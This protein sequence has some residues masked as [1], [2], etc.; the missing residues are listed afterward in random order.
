MRKNRPAFLWIAVIS[1]LLLACN[2]AGKGG[3]Q[4]ATAVPVAAK[5]TPAPSTAGEAI[6]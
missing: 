5:E 2:L 3:S 4:E 6:S 1:I